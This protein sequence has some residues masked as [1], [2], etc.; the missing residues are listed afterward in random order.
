MCID[1]HDGGVTPN[2]MTYIKLI[3][4]SCPLL[5][6]ENVM[7]SKYFLAIFASLHNLLHHKEV[8]TSLLL[9]GLGR[10]VVIS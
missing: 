7:I 8:V 1:T 2:G 6:I 5:L 3:L 10:C 4:S 9:H